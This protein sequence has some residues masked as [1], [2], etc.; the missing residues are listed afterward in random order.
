MSCACAVDQ[1][2]RS[3]TM[4][5]DDAAGA[6]TKGLPEARKN[7]RCEPKV[8]QR[9]RQNTFSTIKNVTWCRTRS[10]WARIKQ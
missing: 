9:S 2:D 10:F 3:S 4:R 7:W 8:V 1:V 6:A 5:E